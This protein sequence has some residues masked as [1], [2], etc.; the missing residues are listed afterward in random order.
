MTKR[1][2]KTYNILTCVSSKIN[3]FF[4]L[5]NYIGKRYFLTE[6]LINKTYYASYKK[7]I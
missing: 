6:Q 3:I 1:S 4:A 7:T 2:V 5:D